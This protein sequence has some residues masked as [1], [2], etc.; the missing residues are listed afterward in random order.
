MNGGGLEGSMAG[1]IVRSVWDDL[2]TTVAHRADRGPLHTAIELLCNSH[3]ADG[4]FIQLAYQPEKLFQIQDNGWG[5]DEQGLEAFFR[6]GDS[7]KREK[8]RTPLGRTPLG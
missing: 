4:Q 5:M 1:T 2:L 6:S 7:E 8:V 3:D